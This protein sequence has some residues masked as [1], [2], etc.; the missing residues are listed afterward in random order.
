MKV[1]VI[2]GGVMGQ[3]HARVLKELG[4]LHSIV[5]KDVIK[6]IAL[7]EKFGVEIFGTLEEADAEA[8]VIA[9]PSSTHYE[10]AK[11][12]LEKGKHVLIEKPACTT[13]SN[14]K[15]LRSYVKDQI[16]A[17]GHI[18]RFNPVVQYSRSWAK[19]NPVEV[20]NSYRL[21]PRPHRIADVGVIADLAIHDVDAQLTIINSR[22]K[23]VFA[24]AYTPEGSKME[25]FGKIVTT[26][27]NGAI[28][29]VEVSWL[30]SYKVRKMDLV[31]PNVCATADFLQQTFTKQASQVSGEEDNGF[32]LQ[33]S[34]QKAEIALSRQEPLRLELEDFLKAIES[35]KQPTVTLDDAVSA[36]EIVD[37]AYLSIKTR[38]TVIL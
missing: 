1:C 21:S 18:E 8:Y 33:I 36:L 4:A 6:S 29:M 20:V 26:F 5:E 27:E 23:S 22:P 10:I 35:K 34:S 2:G 24:T 16:V 31:S 32:E 14:A 9:S 7:K 13:V 19:E 17:V 25:H 15:M 12:L 3:N 30:H 37:A 38:N 11:S 28:G